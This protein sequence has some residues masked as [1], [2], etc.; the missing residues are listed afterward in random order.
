MSKEQKL[1]NNLCRLLYRG[2]YKQFTAPCDIGAVQTDYLLRLLKKN[3]DTV[4]GRS[5]QFDTIRSYADFAKKVPLT[6]YENYEP[7]IR[8]MGDGRRA[9][10]TKEKVR[11]FE[12]T[13]G[14]SGGKKLIPYT[15]SLKQEFGR[16]IRPWLYDIYTNVPGVDAGKSYWSLTPVTS[17]KRYA[18]C[19]IPIGFEEDA[20]YFG[21]LEQ[22]IMRRLFA[23]D[24]SVKFA[25]DREA[26][27]EETARQLLACDCLTLIS[28]WNPSFLTLLC[29]F[30]CE[31][32]DIL[33]AG[34]TGG[35]K[36]VFL[37]A[38]AENRFDRLFSD[39]KLISCWADAG[40]ASCTAPV[41]DRF[42]DVMIQP[43]G[44]LATECFVSF[45]LVGEE[46]ARLSLY[47]HFF[48]FRSLDDGHI[49]TAEGLTRG[50][51]E[52][53]VTTGGG[54][55]RYCIGDIVEV[56]A[57][58]P[59]APPRIRFLGRGGICSDL[60]GEK[61]T[62][63]FV[64]KALNSL[65]LSHCFCLLAPEGTHYC[66]YTTDTHVTS[67]ALDTALCESYHYH[68]CRQLGLLTPARIIPVKGNPRKAWMDRLAAD[69]MRL[70]DIKPSCLSK[71][72]GWADYFECLTRP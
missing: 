46:G 27:Y 36:A 51:Y 17:K 10:L 50:T 53:I 49:V 28:V 12:V 59:H 13:S 72:S 70:G 66:L 67:E 63:Q 16:G 42:P 20:Q 34:L 38:V 21:F 26:F 62:E 24:G 30:M 54:F 15:R 65:R 52:L 11:L 2:A 19:G 32:K 3:A 47:S 56:L 5:Y 68:Y 29:D 6:V 14:S 37:N 1:L 4:Y 48:E 45:P 31:H 44:L 9:V 43:K 41:R 23:V 35:R 40:A 25:T 64:E 39:L 61:L 71:R 60:F 55:Y 18:P 33:A 69:G 8:D 22:G 7:Y 58:Y 57:V